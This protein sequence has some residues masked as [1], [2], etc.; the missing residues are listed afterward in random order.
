MQSKTLKLTVEI[1]I[2]IENGVEYDIQ[3]LFFR[4]NEFLKDYRRG[5]I[6]INRLVE[7]EE[8]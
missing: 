3:A 4:L 1:E 8:I 7:I 5:E 6:C 2:E